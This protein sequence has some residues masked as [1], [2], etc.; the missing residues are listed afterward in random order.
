MKNRALRKYI[1]V[2][3]I[4]PIAL[5]L[6]AIDNPARAQ[7]IAGVNEPDSLQFARGVQTWADNCS[8][9]HNMRDPDE[10]RDD[11][12][13]VIVSHMRVRGGLTGQEARDVLAFLQGGATV[14][15]ISSGKE[16]ISVP[17]A[18][19]DESATESAGQA[20]YAQ[21]CIAC[22]GASGKGAIPGVPD[23]TKGEGP[24]VKSDAVLLQNISEGFQSPGSI[25]AMPAKGGN[26]AL[27][28]VDLKAVLAY[29]R[30]EFGKSSK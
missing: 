26:P 21:T 27:T 17:A 19:D 16:S 11:Q 9:C 13:R 25:M 22:H 3:A 20:I 23:F 4:A 6:L 10:F 30:S 15:P 1:A 18:D 7:D 5:A 14:R 12:W 24:L 2:A 28:S 29:L 8:R